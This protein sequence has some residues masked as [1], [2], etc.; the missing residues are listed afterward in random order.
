[1]LIKNTQLV[2]CDLNLLDES[3]ASSEL[4]VKTRQWRRTRHTRPR[5]FF[6]IGGYSCTFWWGKHEEDF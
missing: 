4:S 3:D 2:E 6:V 1:M 5:P